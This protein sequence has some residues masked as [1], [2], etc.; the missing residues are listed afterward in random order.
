MDQT[1]IATKPTYADI[2]EKSSC[3][4]LDRME[5]L[6]GLGERIECPI[7]N[8]FTNGLYT[9]E[10]FMPAGSLV[11][12]KIHKT[13][14]QF[15]VSKGMVSVWCKDTGWTTFKAPYHGIT[16]PG[17]RRFLY[18]HE[19]TVWTTFHPN[20]ENVEDM[21][22]VEDMLILKHELSTIEDF[23]GSVE[24]LLTNIPLDASNNLVENKQ[25]ISV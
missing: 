25:E 12:S 8:R 18:N 3:V 20:P 10:I 17:A 22:K 9:R 11:C 6:L 13:Q 19:D 24:A 14:H 15:I 21:E 7:V 2:I 5:A 16:E 4:E 23:G 1:L